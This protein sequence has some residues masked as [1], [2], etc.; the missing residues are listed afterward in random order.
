MQRRALDAQLNAQK[1]AA[2][3]SKRAA[4]AAEKYTKATWV[5]IAVT[6]VGILLSAGFQIWSASRSATTNVEII[7]S[8]QLDK[9]LATHQQRL[10]AIPAGVE[11]GGKGAVGGVAAPKP[12][13]TKAIR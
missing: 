4:E 10:D 9:L 2:I 13:Q 5:F 7:L 8:P 6:G 3:A 12:E 1:E 11:P